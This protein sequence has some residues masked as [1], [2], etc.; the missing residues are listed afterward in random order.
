MHK[1]DPR[2]VHSYYEHSRNRKIGTP[3]LEHDSTFEVVVVGG[4]LSG[5]ST[6]LHLAEQGVK[7]AVLEARHF[8]WGASGRSGGQI[9]NGFACGQDT[10]EKLLGLETARQLWD[11]SVKSV[12]YTRKLVDRHRI[13]CDLTMGYMHLAEKRRQVT[14]LEETAADLADKYDYHRMALHDRSGLGT[15]LG[16]DLYAAGLS[17]SGS[18]HLHPLNY[19]LGIAA[20]AKKA[21]ARLFQHSPVTGVESS[22]GRTTVTCN[23]VRIHCDTVVYGC[24]AY[25]DGLAKE[26]SGT[27]MPV[28]TYI[29]ATEPLTE[30]IALELIPSRA[31]MADLNFIL[32]YYRLSADHRMLFGGRVSYS[33]FEPLRLTGSLNRR[34]LR[35]FPRLSGTKIEF[36]W[37]G[38]VAIT[39]NRA[40]HVGR[41]QNGNW[42]VQGYSGHGMALA[43]YMG[44]II[45][46]AVMGDT[47]EFDCFAGIPHKHFPGGRWL[48][49]PGL[50]AAMGYYKLRDRF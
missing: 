21:G 9:I 44:K 33:T 29:I 8:G 27:I 19:C 36:S 45:A 40:P 7:V 37:G 39:R 41:L 48:R 46:R 34:M 25:L 38:Y 23:G 35:V 24:N 28:G 18:G 6:A 12:E 15:W 10:L 11:H 49:M 30:E 1:T 26:I 3:A 14:E 2:P 50:V 22:G 16:S 4:G 5:C 31:A 42:F 13:D 47:D 32:D 20:A 17:D 43:G